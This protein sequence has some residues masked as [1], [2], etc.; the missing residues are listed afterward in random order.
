MMTVLYIIELNRFRSCWLRWGLCLAVSAVNSLY[1]RMKRVPWE[2]DR[3]CTRPSAASALTLYRHVLPELSRH[4]KFVLP[5]IT[6]MERL[7]TSSY[8][9]DGTQGSLIMKHEGSKTIIYGNSHSRVQPTSC[10]AFLDWLRTRKLRPSLGCRYV[11]RCCLMPMVWVN[12]LRYDSHIAVTAWQPLGALKVRRKGL[13]GVEDL[14]LGGN[15]VSAS[16]SCS[17]PS[18]EFVNNQMSRSY[19]LS[20]EANGEFKHDSDSSSVTRNLIAAI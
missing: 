20:L 4:Q 10:V 12:T 1:M 6:S 9:T 7:M 5:S 3:Y 16:P 14:G 18:L 13:N 17:I 11:Q 15:V 19:T 8:I 2:Y